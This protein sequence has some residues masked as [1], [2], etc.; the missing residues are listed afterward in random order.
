[1]KIDKR[2]TLK[3]VGDISQLFGVKDYR[4]I[5]GKAEGV[6]AIDVKNGSG[7]EMT[8]LPDRGLD[9]SHLTYKGINLSY[10]SKTGI[11]APQYYDDSGLKFLR[12]FFGGFL[13]TCGLVQAGA[14][15]V[16]QCQEFGLHGR[17][18]NTPAEEVYA[19]TEF[20]QDTAIMRVRGKV[21][22]AAVFGEN[23]VLN[24]EIIVP[25]GENKFI[26][27]DTVENMGFRD[28]PLMILYHCNLGYPLLTS[29][30]YFIAWSK[31]VH[32]RDE[33]AAKGIN[34]YNK[35]Q[36]PTPN[37]KEQVFYHQMKCDS[38]GKTF[39]ALINPIQ[40]VGIVIWFNKNQ[41]WNLCQW[42]MMGEGEY[43]LGIEPGNC[44]VGGRNR[45]REDGTLEFIKPGEI[46]KFQLDIEILEEQ[47]EIKKLEEMAK[48]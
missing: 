46:R 13:T 17:I 7:L 16:D 34:E 8:I 35:F 40:Q 43:V 36:L 21:R 23:L 10:I 9:I 31:S 6:R 12:S 32:P 25:Y 11:V 44:H 26:I 29:K 39:A 30:S 18:S 24:R 3:Y 38:E 19:G 42:K 20:V 37:Y 2:E 15:C 22:E 41:L 45:A 28:E 33:E 48:L 14:A 5:G 27:N 47:E 4:L 1:M